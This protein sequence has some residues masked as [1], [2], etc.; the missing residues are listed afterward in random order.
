MYLHDNYRNN[1]WGSFLS[2]TLQNVTFEFCIY[3]VCHTTG[4]PSHIDFEDVKADLE[5]IPGVKSA[6]SLHIWSLTTTRTALA[7]HLT[8]E[9]GMN[10]QEVLDKASKMLK[11][12]HNIVHSTLQVEDHHDLMDDCDACQLTKPKSK[13]CW[14]C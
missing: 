6:H 7:A 14:P 5:E 2:L 3:F 4:T 13:F 9:P 10:T 12:N 11:D 1:V 8:I